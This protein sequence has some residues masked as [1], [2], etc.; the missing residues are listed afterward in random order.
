MFEKGKITT[1]YGGSKSGRTAI[2]VSL[3][4][5]KPAV[6]ITDFS[7]DISRLPND[8]LVGRIGDLETYV[9]CGLFHTDFI[10]LKVDLIVI[11]SITQLYRLLNSL[12]MFSE[13]IV[14]LSKITKSLNI[15][16]LLIADT[17]KDF[18]TNEIKITGGGILKVASDILIEIERR[19]PKRFMV[20]KRPEQKEVEFKI[21]GGKAQ[22]ENS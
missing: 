17:Y 14:K 8:A 6:Y 19:G 20:Y 12:K 3:L 11:D 1:I 7:T 16:M 10:K 9:N 2:A 5:D 13:L 4:N 18:N 15:T 21:I 22:W